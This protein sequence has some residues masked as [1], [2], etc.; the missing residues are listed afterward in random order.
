MTGA[1][2][3]RNFLQ[4]HTKLIQSKSHQSLGLQPILSYPAI[5]HCGGHMP[6]PLMLNRVKYYSWGDEIH[7]LFLL[8]LKPG[9]MKTL[10]WVCSRVKDIFTGENS[11]EFSRI[12]KNF[13]HDAPQ[14]QGKGCKGCKNIY[15]D[16]ENEY[17]KRC[18]MHCLF[19][20]IPT[21]PRAL[22]SKCIEYIKRTFLNTQ[23][24]D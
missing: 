13:H 14:W 12:L 11:Q 8:E 7:T 6:P 21:N 9:V 19:E 20:I 5:L 16:N 15:I 4:K 10:I 1:W 17:K 23:L 24:K 3:C 2:K 22:K 18:I